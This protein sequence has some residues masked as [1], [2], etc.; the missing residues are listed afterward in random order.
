[1]TSLSESPAL[2]LIAP[3]QLVTRNGFNAAANT[4]VF[5]RIDARTGEV[6]LQLPDPVRV[7]SMARQRAAL[8]DRQV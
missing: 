5:Q 1:M 8:I 3:T 6:V 7:E 2:G 4:P